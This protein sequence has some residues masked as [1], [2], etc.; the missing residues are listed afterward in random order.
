VYLLAG[1]DK[2]G[3]VVLGGHFR[4]DVTADGKHVR[5]IE[6]ITNGCLRSNPNDEKEAGDAKAILTT[7]HA[8][9]TPN[10]AHVFVNLLHGFPI[11]VGTE[12]GIWGVSQG[13]IQ[14]ASE[15]PKDTPQQKAPN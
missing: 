15:W 6:R 10:E 7:H 2:A 12:V 11:Y 1:T 5:K 3:E 8:S 14:Y 4:V 9:P 13:H